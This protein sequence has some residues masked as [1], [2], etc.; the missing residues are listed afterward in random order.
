MADFIN[1]RQLPSKGAVGNVYRDAFSKKMYLAVADGTLVLLDDLLS[2]RDRVIAVGPAGEQ[3]R[4]GEPGPQGVPGA[5][6]KDGAPGPVGPV[7]PHGTNG[8]SITGKTGR[9]GERGLTGPQGP[10][11]PQGATGAKGD[12]GDKGEPG[13]ILYVDPEEVKAAAL[14]LHQEKAKIS[15]AFYHTMLQARTLRPPIRKLFE[16]RLNEFKRDAGL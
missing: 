14:R 10:Q 11:G 12:K 4:Q 16:L 15:A 13:D 6:G 5:N 9:D 1:T 2:A 3:G 8:I 7:G